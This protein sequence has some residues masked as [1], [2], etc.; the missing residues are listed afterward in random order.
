M[1]TAVMTRT[2]RIPTHF[3]LKDPNKQ[4]SD[5]FKRPGR[6]PLT[7]VCANSQITIKGCYEYY[8]MRK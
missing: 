6:R 8:E 2:K 4:M 7:E 5:V 3:S 1:R